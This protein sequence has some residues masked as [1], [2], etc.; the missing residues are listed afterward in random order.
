MANLGG[1]SGAGRGQWGSRLGFILAASGS[2]IGLGNIW[3]F[4]YAT[5]ANGGGAFVLIYLVC[6][7]VLGLA[8]MWA[9]LAVGRATQK[10]PVGALRA[11]APRSPWVLLGYL[12]LLTGAAIL[13]YYG[14]VAG[15]TLGYLYH[16]FRGNLSQG[17]P[18]EFFGAFVADWKQQVLY[19]TLFMGL[20][21]AVVGGGVRQGIERISKVLMPL[22]L[23][24]LVGL[25]V[26]A[27]M[28][29][30]AMAGL[31]YYLM[32][33]FSQVTTMTFVYALGQAFFS[34]SLGM[35]AMLTYGSYMSR[36][37]DLA[38]AGIYVVLFDTAI[39]LMAGLM[40]FPVLG[41]APKGGGPG[42]VFV[43]L[44]QQFRSMPAGW[45]VGQI[46]FLLLAVAALTSTVS[47]LEVVVSYLVDELKLKRIVAVLLSGVGILLVGVPSA[48]SLGAVPGFSELMTIGGKPAGFLDVMNY[49]FGNLSL[50]VGALLLCLFVVLRWKPAN[51]V[52]EIVSS[53]PWFRSL[54]KPWIVC[55]AVLCPLA[56]FGLLA[57]MLVTGQGLG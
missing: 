34:L 57:Y 15:W 31:R 5:G 10:N 29:P 51:A 52:A 28:Q 35:G 50:T 48:L 7:L 37:E 8:V 26:N 22:L 9:E 14:V 33:D 46:F 13:S 17:D 3:R 6:T 25:I 56:V 18:G 20:T 54:A 27:L 42:L 1:T 2:A 11:L 30:Q 43:V 38:K 21:M 55:V 16:G 4:P 41:G 12:G 49:L 40:I 53:A 24:M 45:L 23:L 44:I 19:L 39:A 36:K 32:P 47:L